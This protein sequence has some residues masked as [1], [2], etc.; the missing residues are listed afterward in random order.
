MAERP[1]LFAGPMVR[2]I[3][4]GRKTQTRRLVKLPKPPAEFYVSR[5]GPKSHVVGVSIVDVRCP[6]GVPGD[7]LWVRETWRPVS[8]EWA[9][10]DGGP[11]IVR[12]AADGAEHM[13]GEARI[14]DWRWPVAARRGDVPGIHMPRWASRIDLEITSVRVERLQDIS[15]EDALAEGVGAAPEDTFDSARGEFASLWNKINGDRATWES[16]PWVWV[17]EFKRVHP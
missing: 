13:H 6:Y 3:L 15:E 9:A 10:P 2:A 1:I 7:R 11:V 12:Y 8:P 5:T 16:N 4:E 17:V 14:G